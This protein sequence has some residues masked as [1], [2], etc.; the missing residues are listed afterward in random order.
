MAPRVPPPAELL[1]FEGKKDYPIEQKVDDWGLTPEQQEA[2]VELFRRRLVAEG[3]WKAD[4]HDYYTLRR[5]LRARTY[6]LERALKMFQDH[7]N[8][9]QEHDIDNI[10]K[11]FHFEER[12]KFLAAYPQGYHKLDKQG[13]PIYIQLIGKIDVHGIL[14]CTDEDRMFKFHVQEYER[15]VKVIMPVC[16]RLANRKIDQ[17][18]GIMDVRGVGISALTG[19][20]KRML[21]KFTKTDQDNYPE[22]LGHICIINAPAIFR[23]VWSIVKGMIDVR[24]QQKIEILGSNYMDAL[25]K[26]VDIECIPE[27]LGGKSHGTLLDDVGP[28][29]NPELMAE[30]GIDL[31]ALRLGLP[32]PPPPPS[33]PCEQ[34]PQSQSQ[35]QLVAASSSFGR[36]STDHDSGGF[37]TPQGSISSSRSLGSNARLAT[38]EV[39]TSAAPP[40]PIPPSPP[41]VVPA[42]G[43]ITEA[44]TRALLERIRVIEGLLPPHAERLRIQTPARDGVSTRS[45]PEGSLLNRVEVMEEALETVLISQEVLI[46][47]TKEQHAAHAAALKAMQTRA[48]ELEQRASQKGCCTIM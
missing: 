21:T 29:S 27:W 31:E 3:I 16:S 22:M 47:Q 30:M 41:V 5:F 38:A 32:S 46:R 14:A 24:T 17:T 25:Q 18:F 48:E 42:L 15:C 40:S 36:P 26:H 6:D 19:D 11:D 2:Y 7:V 37:L 13:R 1:K 8:W 39:T 35:Q 4:D 28:W 34:Q 9:R 33:A 43:T 20:V 44:R 12:G 45:A 23:M 10:L